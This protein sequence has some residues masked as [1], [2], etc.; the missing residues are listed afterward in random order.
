MKATRSPICIK[1]IPKLFS[2]SN[3]DIYEQNLTAFLNY[4]IHIFLVNVC[5]LF[6]ILQSFTKEN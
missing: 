3:N 4:Q 2:I 6:L 5:E 1:I